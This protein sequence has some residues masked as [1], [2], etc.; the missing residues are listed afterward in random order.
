MVMAVMMFSMLM[1][2]AMVMLMVMFSMLMVVMVRTM[3][4]LMMMFSMLMAMMVLMAFPASMMVVMMPLQLFPQDFL[5]QGYRMFHGIEQF[6][7]TEL[8]DGRGDQGRIPLHLLSQ[9]LYGLLY[10]LRLC[11]IRTA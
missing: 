9:E 8:T 4:V 11:Y 5:L 6:L 1:M 10:L 7:S 3:A 2:R